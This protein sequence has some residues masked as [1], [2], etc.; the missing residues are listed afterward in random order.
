MCGITGIISNKKNINQVLYNSLF[1]IQ[2]R[3]QDS[4][5]VLTMDDTNLYFIKEKGLINNSTA[6]ISILKGNM[7]IGHVR[8]TTSGNLVYNEIQPFIIKNIALCH[9]GNISN[10]S[11]IDKTNLNLKTNSDSELILSLINNELNKYKK[12]NDDIIIN[13]IKNISNILVGSY[14]II[15]LIKNYGLICFKDPHGIRPLIYGKKNN[16]YLISSESPSLINNDFKNIKD[17]KA[18]EIIIFKEK[19][20]NITLTKYQYSNKIQ[21]PCI[22]EWIYI[23][24]EDSV[25]QNVSVYEARLKMG[26]LLAKNIQSQVDIN[27]IDYVIPIPTTSK[28]IA[29]KISE[30]LNIPYRECIV[31]NRYIY[32]TFIMN[33][34]EVRNNNIH[35]KLSVVKNIV[36]N[37]NVLIVDDSIVRGNTIK[38]IINLLKENEVNNIYVASCAPI[39]K[40]QNYYG[41]DIPTKEE[42]IANNKTIREIENELQIQKLIYQSIDDLCKSIQFYNPNI[43]DFE[44]SI[45]NGKYLKN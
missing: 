3:G 31:K 29:L 25:I 43:K 5:G 30:V 20:N 21:K 15:L 22:F 35:K 28:P 40:H 17:V 33:N 34:Q 36:K 11:K 9:N 7:G 27:N 37:K 38:H 24:R 16:T 14:S 8:Y 41:L 19:Q 2:H 4:H 44:L 45:F 1:H 39:I 23:A 26:E 10:Y 32:R 6:N 13:T 42:L 18:G 12:I